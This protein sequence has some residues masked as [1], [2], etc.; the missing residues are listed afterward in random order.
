VRTIKTLGIATAMALA[1]IAVAGASMASANEFKTEAIPE[2]WSGTLLGAAHK[3]T[4]NGDTF[5]CSKVAFS[6]ESQYGSE[7]PSVKVT[8]ELN[9]CTNNEST[10]LGW[11]MNGC[12]FRFNAGAYQGIGGLD[13]ID[14]EKAMRSETPSGCITEI[15]EQSGGGGLPQVE[16]KNA[17]SGST[18]TITFIAKLSGISFTRSGVCSAPK[19]TFSNGI[20]SGEWTVKG[21]TSG[22]TQAGLEIQSTP[23]PPG[24]YFHAEQ[25]P[26][27]LLGGYS[28]ETG[29]LMFDLP[30]NG[31]VYCFKPSFSGT[32]LVPTE[33]ITVTPSFQNCFFENKEGTEWY[34]I[35][36]ESLTAGGCSY[37]LP[38]KGG[39]NIVGAT[40]AANPIKVTVTGCVFKVG[41]QSSAVGPTYKNEGTGTSRKVRTEL[42]PQKN[43]YTAEGAGCAKTGTISTGSVKLSGAVFSAKTPGG[44]AQGFWRE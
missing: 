34:S 2:K 14:C 19:G 30:E 32:A 17:G 6:G 26:A 24:V 23:L 39:F 21:S 31:R 9:G 10:G 1:L 43:T 5:T 40:C 4:L 11:K 8:P 44:A 12:K 13:I 27:T 16:Y 20:Y 15:P 25:S 41:P 22:G 36:D 28:S 7:I 37:Q 42:N 33:V 29:R 38:A 3:L 35:P 18:R